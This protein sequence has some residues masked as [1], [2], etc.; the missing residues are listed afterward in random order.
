MRTTHNFKRD[1]LRASV[2]RVAPV[3]QRDEKPRINKVR[4]HYFAVARRLPY[5]T[6]SM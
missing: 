4:L 6:S 2:V 3:E 5:T 1:A